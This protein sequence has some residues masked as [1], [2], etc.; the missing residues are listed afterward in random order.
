MEWVWEL[1]YV[2]SVEKAGPDEIKMD[3]LQAYIIMRGGD[4]HGGGEGI[5]IWRGSWRGEQ[6]K[7]N[8]KPKGNKSQKGSRNKIPAR[9][10]DAEKR[11]KRS[12]QGRTEFETQASRT[13][14]FWNRGAWILTL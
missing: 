5:R 12:G 6:G 2:R 14:E 9:D 11:L 8:P 10:Q 3:M 13:R 4:A 7:P 1:S